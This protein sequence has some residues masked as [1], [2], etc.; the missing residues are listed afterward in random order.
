MF[1]RFFNAIA[2]MT[3]AAESFAASIKEADSRFRSNLALDHAE[4]PPALPDA[5]GDQA[6]GN[7]NG[8]GRHAKAKS[9]V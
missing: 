6:A 4:E 2:A 8:N 5:R 3:A 9:R 7:A 1:R